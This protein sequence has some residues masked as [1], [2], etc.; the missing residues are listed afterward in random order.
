M[1][2]FEENSNVNLNV[3]YSR[4]K[5]DLRYLTGVENVP[6][7]V[8]TT[9]LL[10]LYQRFPSTASKNG[11]ILR[12]MSDNCLRISRPFKH[13]SKVSVRCCSEE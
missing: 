2:F 4:K 9:Q 6:L 12:F 5:F 11:I 1:E 7:Q 3:N 13:L 10:K 8:D